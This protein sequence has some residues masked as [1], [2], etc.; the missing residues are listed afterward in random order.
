MAKQSL[1]FE[2][3][4]LRQLLESWTDTKWK[5]RVLEPDG[6][7]IAWSEKEGDAIKLLAMDFSSAKAKWKIEIERSRWHNRAA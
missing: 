7:Y 3:E 2:A 5:V 6:C 1:R 4:Q